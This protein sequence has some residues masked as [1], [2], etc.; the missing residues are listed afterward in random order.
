[1]SVRPPWATCDL[2]SKGKNETLFSLLTQH[3]SRSL[4]I[5]TEKGS[6]KQKDIFIV[7][8]HVCVYMHVYI[9][10]CVYMCVYMHVCICVCVWSVHIHGGQRYTQ[11]GS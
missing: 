5:I 8:V 4:G 9:C 1:M 7:C 6:Y 2:F 11:Y 3:D 10:V